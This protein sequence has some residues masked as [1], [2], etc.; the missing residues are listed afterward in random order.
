MLLANCVGITELCSS[1]LIEE[2]AEGHVR[3]GKTAWGKIV[4]VNMCVYPILFR[5]EK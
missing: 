5:K 2:E 3:F 1:A 4:L